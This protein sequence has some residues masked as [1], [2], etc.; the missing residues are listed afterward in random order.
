MNDKYKKLT[1]QLQNILKNVSDEFILKI[2]SSHSSEGE[3][4][5]DLIN[6][7]LSSYLSSMCNSMHVL[8]EP[9]PKMKEIVDEFIEKLLDHVSKLNPI[10]NMEVIIT[11]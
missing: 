9:H 4:T 3:D 1:M 11:H 6:L 10:K 8:A 7:I 2:L 5:S